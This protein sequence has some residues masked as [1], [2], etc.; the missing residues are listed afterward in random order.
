MVTFLIFVCIQICLFYLV[1]MSTSLEQYLKLCYSQWM[2]SLFKFLHGIRSQIL[3]HSSIVNKLFRTSSFRFTLSLSWERKIS[4]VKVRQFSGNNA[5]ILQVYK[6]LIASLSIIIR[7]YLRR[8]IKMP[9]QIVRPY[10]P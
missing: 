7:V 8:Y 1:H 3:N 10:A 5:I 6:V 9:S 4:K 2:R